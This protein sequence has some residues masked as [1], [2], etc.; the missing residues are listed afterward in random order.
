MCPH[1]QTP[2]PAVSLAKETAE[3]DYNV[4]E[5]L[6]SEDVVIFNQYLRLIQSG[7]LEVAVVDR[8]GTDHNKELDEIK[9]IVKRGLKALQRAQ[10]RAQKEAQAKARQ[11]AK[12]AQKNA[13][14]AARQAKKEE[15]RKKALPSA[16]TGKAVFSNQWFRLKKPKV[17]ASA[18]I[19]FIAGV[20]V[21]FFMFSQED[22]PLAE[23]ETVS[24]ALP[25]VVQKLFLREDR[26]A[27]YQEADMLA[28][29]Q[30][31]ANRQR[32]EQMLASGKCFVNRSRQELKEVEVISGNLVRGRA[33]G[34]D[35]LFFHDESLERQVVN[36]P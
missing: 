25:P 34:R 21:V 8:L 1:C 18:L 30:A 26:V 12:S 11:D 23:V 32:Y 7:W 28:I 35:W 4:Y 17:F 22:I 10:E 5:G 33:A 20:M 36:N 15:K 14:L 9:S 24:P 6:S 27:C 3:S 16:D 19:L 31:A 13:R 29:T 2:V